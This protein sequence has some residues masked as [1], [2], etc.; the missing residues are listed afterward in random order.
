M[1]R[2]LYKIELL[3]LLVKLTVL[4]D[5]FIFVTFYLLYQLIVA[6]RGINSSVFAETIQRNYSKYDHLSPPGTCYGC[7]VIKW[8]FC[9]ERVRGRG[10]GASA[11]VDQFTYKVWMSDACS[12][13][14]AV[15]AILYFVLIFF[16]NYTYELLRG[17]TPAVPRQLV[18]VFHIMHQRRHVGTIGI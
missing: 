11:K 5:L 6:Q 17:L 7:F 15:E 18:M 13:T 8:D 9:G 14:A 12:A 3:L 2:A 16:T 4:I 1:S 10:M